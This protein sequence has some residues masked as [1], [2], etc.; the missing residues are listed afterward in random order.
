LVASGQNSR[1]FYNHPKSKD[2]LLKQPAGSDHNGLFYEKVAREPPET[3]S[4]HKCLHTGRLKFYSHQ[5]Q[6][7]AR[8]SLIPVVT[9]ET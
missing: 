3:F 8:G 7:L 2:L 9:K 6:L 4:S 1:S 5:K